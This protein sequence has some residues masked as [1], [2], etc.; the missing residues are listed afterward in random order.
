METNSILFRC[1]SLHHLMTEPKNK[2]ELVAEGV[3]AHLADV[4]ASWKYGRREEISSKYLRKGNEREED[5]ISL[6]SIHQK[7]FFKKNQE[8]LS[9]EYIS[10]TPDLFIGESILNSDET[11]D[12]KTSWSLNTFLRSKVKELDK[13]YLWQ[14]H[15]YIYLTG[16]KKHT[17][18]YCLVNGTAQA[19]MD[20]KRNAAW[21]MGEMNVMD[22][23]SDAYTERCKQIEINHIF[24]MR[25]FLDENP[26]FDFAVDINE[27]N[28][29]IPASKRVHTFEFER[30]EDAIKKIIGK[31]I[32][33]R[34]W[35]ENNLT[36]H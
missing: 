17:V 5:A 28:Y 25:K 11:L 15:G 13:A 3:K 20:E 27:W 31:V 8:R 26:G 22:N 18:A 12:T 21:D 35:I 33:A 19:I 1:S 4:Y 16:A 14:G 2:A 34:I 10:G 7:R 36:E 32:T 24:D 9:N 29:D 6:L 23:P 30:D